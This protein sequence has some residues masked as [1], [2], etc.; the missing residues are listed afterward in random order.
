M[1]FYTLYGAFDFLNVNKKGCWGAGGGV[2][3]VHNE[4][5]YLPCR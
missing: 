3:E 2:V 1:Y 4:I 5:P